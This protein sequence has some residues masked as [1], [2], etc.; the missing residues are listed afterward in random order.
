MLKALRYF[1]FMAVDLRS[2]VMAVECGQG[3]VITF[4]RDIVGYD[5]GGI[6]FL[7]AKGEPMY[8]MIRASG[9]ASCTGMKGGTVKNRC[10]LTISGQVEECAPDL[11]DE[12][13][14]ANTYLLDVYERELAAGEMAAFRLF[15]GV[16]EY[17]D[18]SRKPAMHATFEFDC[19]SFQ[20]GQGETALPGKYVVTKA[21]MGCGF[22]QYNCSQR[23]ITM[24]RRRAVIDRRF[25]V[26]CNK[27]TRV[28]PVK[29]I[30]R[31]DEVGEAEE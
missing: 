11:V 19:E 21:C 23:C 25:C 24:D 9:Y 18:P 6:Y 27:C 28:C 8:D 10:T 4:A 7:V 14:S 30:K 2:A 22:C 31:I 15:R 1:K 5:E 26:N 20:K 29:A 17:Y 16:G 3:R 12:L 13:V